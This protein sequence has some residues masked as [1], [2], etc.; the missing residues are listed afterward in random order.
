MEH[1]KPLRPNVLVTGTPCVGKTL[2]AKKLAEKLSLEHINIGD[3]A[4]SKNF[5]DGYDEERKCYILDEDKVHD[6]STVR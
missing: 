6:P 1:K 3:F 4:V 2:L 5:T